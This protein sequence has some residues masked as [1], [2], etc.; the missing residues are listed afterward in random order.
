MYVHSSL[1]P[2]C[3][4][5]HS[6]VP[7]RLLFCAACA[8]Q[9][10]WHRCFQLC[11]LIFFLDHPTA[12]FQFKNSANKLTILDT[13][14]FWLVL[15]TRLKRIEFFIYT[16]TIHLNTILTEFGSIWFRKCLII[17][18]KFTPQLHLN[19]PPLP[20]RNGSSISHASLLAYKI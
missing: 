18:S 7:P 11:S 14:T 5:P 4:P 2:R 12:I 13:K 16:T 20:H 3:P 17:P 10:I 6:S 15:G 1:G 8:M 9:W 19:R